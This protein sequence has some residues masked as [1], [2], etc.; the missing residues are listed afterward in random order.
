MDRKVLAM[1]LITLTAACL[2]MGC[3]GK[4]NEAT[5]TPTIA[6]TAIPSLTASATVQASIAPGQATVTPAPTS[7]PASVNPS[8][9]T[10]G[11][12]DSGVAGLNP[13]LLDVSGEG[14]DEGGFPDDGLPTPTLD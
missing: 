1:I 14:Q 9:T 7:A 10:S 8:A 12:T 11:N 2:V 6:P 5:A 13:S 4:R 3:A